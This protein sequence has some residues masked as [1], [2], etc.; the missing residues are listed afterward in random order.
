MDFEPAVHSPRNSDWKKTPKRNGVYS[1]F[2][3]V[4]NVSSIRGSAAGIEKS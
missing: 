2:F 4:I 1:G 3:K